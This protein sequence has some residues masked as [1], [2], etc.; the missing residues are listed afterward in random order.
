MPVGIRT[1][2]QCAEAILCTAMVDE[3]T[4]EHVSIANTK[5]RLLHTEETL[6]RAE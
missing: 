4:L 2:S 1:L 6:G 3:P 5:A